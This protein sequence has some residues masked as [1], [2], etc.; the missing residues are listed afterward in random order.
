MKVRNR[1][2]VKLLLGL[3]LLTTCIVSNSHAQQQG[4]VVPTLVN[5][6]GILTDASGKPLRGILGVTFYLYEDEQGGAPLW[7]ET[8]N[9]HPDK[10]G[11]Y[12]VAL[13][14]TTAQGLPASLFTSG[15]ARW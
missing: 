1:S 5:F 13:G 3:V 10:A 14:S 6:S 15:E 2:V 11:H 4:S 12:T 8:Q 9:V 7:M